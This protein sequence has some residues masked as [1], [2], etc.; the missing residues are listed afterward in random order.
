M[1]TSSRAL[2]CRSGVEM[3]VSPYIHPP[4][5]IATSRS[6]GLWMKNI[7]KLHVSDVSRSSGVFAMELCYESWCRNFGDGLP[8]IMFVA[9]SLPFNEVLEPSPVPMTVE[10]LLYFPLH[11]SIDDYG[12]WVVF[13]FSSWNRVVWSQSEL[14]YVKHW[15][16]LLHPVW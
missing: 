4:F 14:Y 15:M 12:Q 9:I 1:L 13:R 3:E 8:G 5:K 16:E 10:Y 2:S 6:N 11:F 7:V